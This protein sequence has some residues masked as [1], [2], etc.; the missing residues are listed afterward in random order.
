MAH[1]PFLFYSN[2]ISDLHTPFFVYIVGWGS[3]P[4]S[5]L[6]Y[7]IWTALVANG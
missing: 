4:C 5:E 7:L 2:F 3:A 1:P 6:A